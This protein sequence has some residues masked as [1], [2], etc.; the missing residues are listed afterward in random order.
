MVKPGRNANAERVFSGTGVQLTDDAPNLEYKAGRRHLGAAVG[1][2]EYVAAY[3]DEKV[4]HWSKQLADVASTE[5]HAAYAAFVFGLRHRWTFVQCTM[6]TASEH[7]VPLKN[8]IHSR[9]I[10]TLTK[11]EFNDLEMELV[12][13]P[14][15]YGGMSFDDPVA[16]SSIKHTDSL[17][18]TATLTSLLVDGAT[19]LPAGSDLDHHLQ[20][21]FVWLRCSWWLL[22]C[23]TC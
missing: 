19:D 14:A 22:C 10:L 15:R 4:A 9:L 18:Y 11:H 1:S 2:A 16:D 6:P 5:P 3:L 21:I 8:A 12:T 17:E 13:L 7:M 20:T 23:G